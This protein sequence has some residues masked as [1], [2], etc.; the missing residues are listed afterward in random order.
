MQKDLGL[1]RRRRPLLAWLLAWAQVL[2]LA[3]SGCQHRIDGS[4]GSGGQASLV[5]G[6]LGSNDLGEAVFKVTRQGIEKEPDQKVR[7][8]S[9]AA[10]DG[11]HKPFVK[12]VNDI[13]NLRTLG[14]VAQSA[15]AIFKLIDDDTIPSL[16]EDGAQVLELLAKDPRALDAVAALLRSRPATTGALPIDDLVALLGRLSNYPETEQLWTASADLLDA[17]KALVKDA[18]ALAS[19]ELRAIP[20]GSNVGPKGALANL[21]Q[22]IGSTILDEAKLRSQFDFGAPEWVVRLD[23]RGVPIVAKDASGRIPPPFVDDGQGRARIDALGRLVD[24]AGKPIDVPPFDDPKKPGRDASGRSVG[25]GGGLVY[26]YFDAKK[27]HLALALKLGGDLLRRD[28]DAHAVAIL[29]AALGPPRADKS[30]DPATPVCDLVH[31]A[32][33]LLAPDEAPKLLR[34]LSTVVANDPARA[35]KV[36]VE[37]SRAVDKLRAAHAA[38][39]GAG[40]LA[41]LPLSDP[42]MV[43]LTDD[44]LPIVD[45]ICTQPASGGASTARTLMDVLNDLRQSAPDWPARMAPLFTNHRISPQ[46]P[47]DTSQ[48]SLHNG[49]DNRSSVQQLLSLLARSDQCSLPL[50]GG[51]SLAVQLIDMMAGLSPSTVATLTSLVTSLPGFLTNLACPGISNDIAALDDLAK[52]GSLDAFLPIAKAF[53]DRGETALLVKMLVRLDHDYEQVLRPA[54]PD[55]ARILASGAVEEVAGI[56]GDATTIQDPTTGASCADVMADAIARLVDQ[57]SSNVSD[58]FGNRVPSAAHLLLRP[59]QAL[60]ARL[61]AAGV[62]PHADALVDAFYAVS[63]K[64]VTVNGQEKLE[65]ETLMPFIAKALSDA[66]ATLPADA[67]TRRSEVTSAQKAAADFIPSSTSGTLLAIH[68]A[69]AR[70]P[71]KAVVSRSI[72]NL[73]TPNKNVKDDIFGAV[74][75]VLAFGLQLH[76]QSAGVSGPSIADL[77]RFAGDAIDPSRPLVQD[78]VKGI[79]KL[80]TADKGKTVLNLERAALNPA[81]GEAR[82]PAAILLHVMQDV[83]DAGVAA[84]G[85]GGNTTIGATE[86]HDGA[87]KIVAWIRDKRTGLGYIFDLIKR[88]KK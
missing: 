32:L 59:I 34:A 80:L 16:A 11:H 44:L 64:R 66:A 75:K 48:P 4:G 84:A 65:N 13:A 46:V 67:A 33:E 69:I 76:P 17:N 58:R 23:D 42:R 74:V 70:S 28:A 36:I 49:V 72:V 27:T 22:R 30:Y 19:R 43:K 20:P 47:V 51:K 41:A 77:L 83:R 56:V 14:N 78:M 2:P 68:G 71:Q 57:H 82:A 88:R 15:E 60:D 29:E 73:L 26:V 12:A 39:A 62:G 6:I 5:A 40:G 7:T 85:G 8:A 24:G 10:L 50:S 21:I 81:P 53:K 35:E 54:E 3:L 18:L 79:T 38:S 55:I 1:S 9:L 86:V 63:L 25:T 87:Q 31:G 45:G 37:I 52:S 61:R